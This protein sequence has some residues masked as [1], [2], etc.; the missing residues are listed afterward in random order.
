[1]KLFYTRSMVLMLL[2][3]FWATLSYS[4]QLPP[5]HELTLHLSAVDRNGRITPI[6]SMTTRTDAQGK[7]QFS[8]PSVPATDRAQYLHLRV[9]DGSIMLRQALTPAPEPGARAD[10]GISEMSDLH[11]R[12]LMNS[13]VGGL[14]PFRMVAALIMLRSPSILPDDAGRIET[15]L[16][17]ATDAFYASLI[18]GGATRDQVVEFDRELL[19]GVR[20]T[21]TLYRQSVDDSSVSSALPEAAGRDKAMELLMREL[22]AA[23]ASAGI[24][25][26]VAEWAY[27]AAG[28]AAEASLVQQKAT[29]AL[30][31]LVRLCFVNGMV[32]CQTMR[33]LKSHLDAL[34]TFGISP[35]TMQKHFIFLNLLSERITERLGLEQT[36]AHADP[37]DARANEVAIF[38]TLAIRDISYF[39]ALLDAASSGDPGSSEYEFLLAEI[40]SR[41]AGTGDVMA[42][43]TRGELEFILGSR[44]TSPIGYQ[45]LPVWLYLQ[46]IPL[47]RYEPITGLAQGIADP[48]PVPSSDLLSG[49]YRA[50][51]LLQ[52]DLELAE[53]LTRQ[54]TIAAENAEPLQWL[55]LSTA[56]TLKWSAITRRTAVMARIS[57]ISQKETEAIMTMSRRLGFY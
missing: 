23:G 14:S 44:T 8:F 18:S 34:W 37:T 32:L 53:Q 15:A 41:M 48:P 28:G 20:R 21:M 16:G 5:H 39:E 56:A 26:D 55:S 19:A 22:I 35:P 54:D 4:A 6:D 24:P 36:L 13:V 33:V 38:D 47:Y 7:F 30:K 2:L 43:M 9:S 17:A 57:G 3:T 45:Q 50:Q 25:L 52:H 46:H 51:A 42:G 40:I 12:I 11:T 49:A 10:I 29:P 31:S 27:M 1:M